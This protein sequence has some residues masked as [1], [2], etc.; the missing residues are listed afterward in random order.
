[1]RRR[2]VINVDGH[3]SGF[4]RV[5]VFYAIGNCAKSASPFALLGYKKN[6]DRRATGGGA[7]PLFL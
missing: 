1:M 5:S 2:L 4:G 7:A 6:G 3:F